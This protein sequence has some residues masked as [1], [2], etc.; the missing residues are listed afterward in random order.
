M[1]SRSSG[2]RHPATVYPV[3]SLVSGHSVSSQKPG[4]RPQCI[5]SDARHPATVYP[6]R[7]LSYG[8]SVSSQKPAIWPQ[9]K[10]PEVFS[11]HGV[12]SQRSVVSDTLD[13]VRNLSS[14]HSTSRQKS[15][16]RPQCILLQACY[17]AILY[18]V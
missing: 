12:S 10:Q 9:C 18:Q 13:P 8:P 2:A 6:V 11:G 16:I 4:I 15:V 7:S 17:P 1:V 14:R 3:R 5:Q